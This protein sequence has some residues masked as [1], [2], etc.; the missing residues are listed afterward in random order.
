MG[1]GG[2][3]IRKTVFA[4]VYI[5]KYFENILLKNHWFRKAEIYMKKF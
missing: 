4:C 3:T 2:T 1:W 5:G